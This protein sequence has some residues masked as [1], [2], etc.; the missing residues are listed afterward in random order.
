MA[1]KWTSIFTSS[2]ATAIK[3]MHR[4]LLVWT[5]DLPLQGALGAAESTLAMR[6]T[7]AAERLRRALADLSVRFT[8]ALQPTA[9]ALGQGLQ[10]SDEAIQ[11]F[12]EE[13]KLLISSYISACVRCHFHVECPCELRALAAPSSP[14]ALCR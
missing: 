13:V 6:A 10:L 8:K 11:L 5:V 14:S 12:S 2:M 3:G 4:A 7:A 9:E 1:W